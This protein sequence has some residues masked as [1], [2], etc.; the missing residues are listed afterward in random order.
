MYGVTWHFL[1]MKGAA[2]SGHVFLAQ[3]KML[4]TYVSR[5]PDLGFSNP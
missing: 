1:D 3:R 5:Q 4:H 2:V